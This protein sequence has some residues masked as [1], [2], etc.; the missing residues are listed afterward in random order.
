VGTSSPRA[1]PR[2][3]QPRLAHDGS[4][5]PWGDAATDGGTLL[6]ERRFPDTV[7]KRLE[8]MGH[9]VSEGLSAHGGYQAVWRR[10]D[11]RVYFGGSDPRKD[12]AALGY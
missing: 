2:S 4:S 9:H 6:F 12:G 3:S 1:T 7:K 8:E 10:D 11:P 5:T